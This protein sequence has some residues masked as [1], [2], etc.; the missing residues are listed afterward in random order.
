MGPAVITA[1]QKISLLLK[2][3]DQKNKAKK[4][5][6][7]KTGGSSEERQ[8]DDFVEVVDE[9]KAQESE[10]IGTSDDGSDKQDELEDVFSLSSER[11][12]KP[13][14][15]PRPERVGN[16][17]VAQNNDYEAENQFEGKVLHFLRLT[18]TQ[19]AEARTRRSPVPGVSG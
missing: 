3:T 8:G 11:L 7:E 18:A 2:M 13:R 9:T 16:H 14:H 10:Y 19:E 1:Q 5:K 15:T 17:P 12:K 4:R 6:A